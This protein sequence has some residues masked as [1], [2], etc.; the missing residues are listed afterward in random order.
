MFVS[1]QIR[2]SLLFSLILREVE[3]RAKTKN[4]YSENIN[5]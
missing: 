1:W 2:N 4:S 3:F 5:V